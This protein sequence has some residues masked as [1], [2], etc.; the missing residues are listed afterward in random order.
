[1]SEHETPPPPEFLSLIPSTLLF[2]VA[3]V[4]ASAAEPAANLA[5]VVAVECFEVPRSQRKLYHVSKSY[6]YNSVRL[7]NVN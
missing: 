7:L 6:N 3:A 2:S 1:M 4:L 5:N